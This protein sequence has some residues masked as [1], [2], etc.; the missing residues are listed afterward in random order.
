MTS[1]MRFTKWGGKLH[2]VYPME[3]LGSDEHGE[4]FGGR[5]GITLRRGYEEPVTQPHD[6]VQLIPAHGCW[7]AAFNDVAAETDI[8]VYI[9]VTTRPEVDGDV[10]HAVD[11]DLDVVRLRD[12]SVRVLD[13]DEF[14]EHRVL[15]G[16]PAEVVAQARATCDDLVARLTTA[17]TAFE[18]TAV[19]WLAQL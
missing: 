17:T 19:A 2:W 6:F 14:D 13:E 7:I 9:D 12:G 5:K 18:K 10:I 8:A 11:L 4:W 1:Q 3:P 15:Y 16:Y